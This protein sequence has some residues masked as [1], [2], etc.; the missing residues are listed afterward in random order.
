MDTTVKVYAETWQKLSA[1]LCQSQKV[2][3]KKVINWIEL[4]LLQIGNEMSQ[5]LLFNVKKSNAMQ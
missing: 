1:M 4:S 3:L 2:Y 5:K